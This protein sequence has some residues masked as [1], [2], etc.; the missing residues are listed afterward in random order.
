MSKDEITD[1][2]RT[3]D[4]AAW[5]QLA[6]ELAE[7]AAAAGEVPVGAV[8]VRNGEIIGRG[9]N[10]NLMD[11]DPTAHAELVALREAAARVGNHRVG[12]CV[13]V[14][15]KEPC[16]MCAGA[17]V[18]ARVKR[19]VYGAKDPK[20]GA[21]GSVLTVLNHPGLNHRIEVTEG[22]LAERCSKVL[23]SFFQARRN[24]SKKE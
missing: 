1:R 6:L 5:M 13:L 9:H 22:V 11:N 2:N 15:T 7:A 3:K 8:V 20:A 10:R 12:E 21:D 18:H 23:T 14:S 19:L 16:A 4:D 24:D 17:M